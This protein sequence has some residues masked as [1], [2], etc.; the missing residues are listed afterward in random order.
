MPLDKALVDQFVNVTT[1][2]ALESSFL[3][4]KNNKIAAYKAAVDYMRTELNKMN[5]R[6]EI[7][8]GEG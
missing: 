4:G 5:I 3:V 2:A 7:V 1:K 6:G 8:I